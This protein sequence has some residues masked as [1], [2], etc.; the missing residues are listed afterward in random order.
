MSKKV[1]TVRPTDSVKKAVSIMNRYNIGSVIVYGDKVEGIITERDVLKRVVALCKDSGVACRS[2]MSRNITTIDVND[3]IEDAI[4]VMAKKRIK[5]LPV[6]E[7]GELVGIVT[8]TDIIK[9]G[10]RVE[11]A[12][13]K[14]LAQFFPVYQASREA[15]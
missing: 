12:A 7:N 13:L 5:K 4:E 6:T 14:K 1:R 11:Y 10:E 9:S 8:A 2:V 3:E 15:G